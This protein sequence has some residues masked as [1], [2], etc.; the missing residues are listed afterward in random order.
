VT[1]FRRSLR[2]RRQSWFGLKRHVKRLLALP[3]AHAVLRLVA[4]RVPGLRI[5]RLPAPSRIR[6][7]TGTADGASFVL[8]RPD[9]CEI[10]KELYWGA[11]RRPA[12]EDALALDVVVRLSRDADVLLDIGAYTGIFTMATTAANPHLRAH[13]F[14]IVPAVAAALEANVERNRVADRVTV[15][16]QGVGDP[17]ATMRVPTGDGGSA[18]PS[19]Y[20]ASMRF[21]DG[22]DVTFR[23]LDDLGDQ[24][25]PAARFLLKVDVEGAEPVVLRHGQRFLAARRPDM[26]CEVLDG[27]VDGQELT[28]LLA[29]HGLRFYL[30]RRHDLLPADRISPH[31][32]F[33]DWL[34]TPRSPQE[35]RG[36]GVPVA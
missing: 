24:E 34:V 20:S 36:I 19:F 18:L 28:D 10:A 14:E 12:P 23:S 35:L 8:V 3:A 15:H 7:V 31:A 5:G 1:D 17:T 13:A 9:R 26:L 11:G 25:D 4:P 30:V 32:D 16:R 6:E 22:T 29:P 33:R 21:D 27:V 2:G